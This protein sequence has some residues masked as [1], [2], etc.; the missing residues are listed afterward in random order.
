MVKTISAALNALVVVSEVLVTMHRRA[1]SRSSSNVAK[2]F[3]VIDGKSTNLLS[4]HMQ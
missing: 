2:L 3:K 4:F 1:A